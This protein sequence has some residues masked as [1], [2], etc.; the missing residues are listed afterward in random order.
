MAPKGHVISLKF[1]RFDVLA[2]SNG[3]CDEDYIQV[4][5]GPDS[6]TRPIGISF[7]N[8]VFYLCSQGLYM[9][10]I[11]KVKHL[12]ARALFCCPGRPNCLAAF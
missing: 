11:G 5:D 12:F 10:D 9:L 6:R 3:F 4:F 2:G 1:T 7:V 8:T